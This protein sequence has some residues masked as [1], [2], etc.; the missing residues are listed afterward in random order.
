MEFVERKRRK[1]VKL[2]SF[3]IYIIFFFALTKPL[4]KIVAAVLFFYISQ[5]K[6]YSSLVKEDA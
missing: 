6:L 5:P 2:N 4:V 3:A 1:T